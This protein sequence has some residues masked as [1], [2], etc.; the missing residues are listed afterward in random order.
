MASN[1]T[2]EEFGRGN[3]VLKQASIMPTMVL[4][5]LMQLP[6]ANTTHTLAIL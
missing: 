4:L 6:C 1:A 3:E 5:L 2:E